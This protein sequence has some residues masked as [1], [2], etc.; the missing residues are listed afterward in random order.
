MSLIETFDDHIPG[1]H[2]S[3]ACCQINPI[4]SQKILQQYPALQ[5]Q[6]PLPMHWLFTVTGDSAD[7][8]ESPQRSALT[9]TNS[10][11]TN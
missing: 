2:I 4:S 10:I 11:F 3:G 8:S 5:L 7:Q 9:T 1:G 6:L